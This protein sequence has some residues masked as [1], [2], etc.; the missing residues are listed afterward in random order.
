MTNLIGLEASNAD[1]TEDKVPQIDQAR[2]G[3]VFEVAKKL[4]SKHQ[5][6]TVWLDDVLEWGLLTSKHVMTKDGM[7]CYDTINFL[8]SFTVKQHV[9]MIRGAFS[10]VEK[11]A[12]AEIL[13]DSK[14]RIIMTG[15][16]A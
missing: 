14:T 8:D 15:V 3:K 2:L 10:D 13:K 6:Q 7:R 5:I 9:D 4:N 12:Q 11:E 16:N 1:D